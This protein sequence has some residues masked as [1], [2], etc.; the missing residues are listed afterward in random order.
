[1]ILF[2]SSTTTTLNV[3]LDLLDVNINMVDIKLVE[4]NLV[5]INIH[6]L[7]VEVK[8]DI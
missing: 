4:I 3:V 7:D 1:M 5:D 6:L 8:L 2:L